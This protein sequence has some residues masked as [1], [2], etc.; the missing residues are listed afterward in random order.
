MADEQEPLQPKQKTKPHPFDG[1]TLM[2]IAWA[3]FVYY[4]FIDLN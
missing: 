4:I 3:F 1:H 2:W